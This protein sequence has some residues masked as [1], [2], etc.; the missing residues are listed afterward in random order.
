MRSRCSRRC[1]PFEPRSRGLVFLGRPF[2]AGRRCRSR[3]V[4][5]FQRA[6]RFFEA[7][8]FVAL[9]LA[10]YTIV[11]I[12]T[13]KRLTA[14]SKTC[15]FSS[16]GVGRKF[17]GSGSVGRGNRLLTR[18]APIVR[19]AHGHSLTVAAPSVLTRFVGLREVVAAVCDRVGAV[20]LDRRLD[21][22][23]FAI[24]GLFKVRDHLFIRVVSV[25][26]L[27]GAV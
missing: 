23:A 3:F 16:F 8:V 4:S 20:F 19:P 18:A 17:D 11:P 9:S 22:V 21:P 2:T 15:G 14:R 5:P 25:V 7:N 1:G 12:R 6:S 26:C 10:H 27:Q 24:L 13:S